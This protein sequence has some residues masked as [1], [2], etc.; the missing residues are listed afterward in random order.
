VIQVAI[1]RG[2]KLIV[3]GG[4][5]GTLSAIVDY[6]AYQ[7]VVVGLLPLGTGNSFARSLGIPLSLEGAIE[8]ITN[9]KVVDIDLGKV[10]GDYFANVAS[11]GFSAEVARKTSRRLWATRLSTSP[12]SPRPPAI[13]WR[14]RWLVDPDRPTC[15]A[16][17]GTRGSS[18]RRATRPQLLAAGSGDVWP[19]DRALRAHQP[20]RGIHLARRTPPVRFL[21]DPG[22]RHLLSTDLE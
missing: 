2:N 17:S 21:L 14:S 1:A 4:G 19:G 11:I 20:G 16:H 9:G 10:D 18:H 5:D 15:R 13:T 3:V 6:F 8:G 22:G 7:N 12:P